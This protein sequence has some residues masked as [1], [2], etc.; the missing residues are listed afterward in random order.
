MKGVY[1]CHPIG[2]DVK[3]NTEKA[4]VIYRDLW[5]NGKGIFPIAPYIMPLLVGWDDDGPVSR[6]RGL[7]ID[8]AYVKFA[9]EVWLY[10]DRISPGMWLEIT[11]AKELGIPVIPKTEGTMR[12]LAQAF[13]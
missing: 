2:G 9:D 1:I 12:D 8:C 10:G 4:A 13:E 6:A 7:K 11:E 3:A 5:E